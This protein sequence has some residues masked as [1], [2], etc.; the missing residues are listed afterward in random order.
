MRALLHSDRGEGRPV[1]YVPGVDG[2]GELLLGT[3][4]RLRDAFRLLCLA[5]AA[6]D[7]PDTYEHLAAT[8]AEVVRGAGVER[9]LLLSESFGGAVALRTALDHTDLVAGVAVVNGFAHY[10]R[11]AALW[12]SRLAMPLVPDWAFRL[13]RRWFAP[14]KLFGPDASEDVLRRFH[15]LPAGGG[16]G[17][18]YRRRLA[19][20]ARVDL[21]PDLPRLARPVTLFVSGRDRI[22]ASGREAEEMAAL[23]PDARIEHIESAGHVVLP[24][25]HVPWIDH[26]HALERRA[27]PGGAAPREVRAVR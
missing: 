20:I 15:A 3:R 26:L 13:G 24:S 8:V 16:F 12:W 25:P 18:G 2:T 19:M 17:P 1:V 11:R 9:C 4:E 5:Y 7:E 23:L 10:S 21:R 14:R 6:G 27:F 22:V